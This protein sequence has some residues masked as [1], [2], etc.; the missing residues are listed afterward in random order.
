MQSSMKL[1]EAMYKAAQD[2]TASES[3]DSHDAHTDS[4]GSASDKPAEGEIL[5]AQFEDISEHKHNKKS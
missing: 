1:G 5:D 4:H 2:K 3:T